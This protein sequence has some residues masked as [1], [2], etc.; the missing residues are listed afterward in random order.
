MI[1]ICDL[2]GTLY[3]NRHRAH[4]MPTGDNRNSTE[5][6]AQFNGA[7]RGDKP[8]PNMLAIIKQLLASG[9]DVR[10]LTGRGKS[11]YLPTMDRLHNDLELSRTLIKL[12]MRPMDDH[13]SA[14]EF[15]ADALLRLLKTYGTEKFTC[16]EDD[17]KVCAAFEALS[18]R[19]I[20]VQVDSLCA[21]VLD[22]ES[23]K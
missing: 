18:D 6:W 22:G 1:Y 14:E 20:V 5:A 21:A 11:A 7:C 9:E 10:F 15:K 8:I 19:V 13:R 17:P 16:F 3:D 2:D 23:N 4:L 12:Q